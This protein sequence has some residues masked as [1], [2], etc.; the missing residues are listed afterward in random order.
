MS[1]DLQS[2][3][4]GDREVGRGLPCFVIAEAGVN[5]N[6]DPEKAYGLIDIALK[7]GADAVKFQTFR[8]DRV[9]SPNAPK[10]SYQVANAAGSE[11]QL[12]MIR[13]LELPFEAF[14]QLQEYCYKRGILFLS[15]PFD[16]DSLE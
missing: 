13:R 15:T 5:H 14:R 3:L 1:R 9:V 7:A 2:V 16:E 6:G 10:A 12:D 11:S 4:I 8:S